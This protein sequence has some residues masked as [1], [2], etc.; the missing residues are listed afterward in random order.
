MSKRVTVLMGGWSSEREVSLTSGTECAEALREGG[1]EVREI[2]VTRDLGRLLAA[3]EPCPNVAFNALHGRYGEDGTIQAV[4]NILDIPYT[5]SGLLASATAMDKARSAAMRRSAGV[6]RAPSA[7]SI[8]VVQ[9]RGVATGCPR[10]G[11]WPPGF[12][13]AR[14][15]GRAVAAC[16][17]V[18]PE[19]NAGS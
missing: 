15:P 6:P 16:A 9:S 8:A 19:C 7:L 10:P 13:R 1:Y 18:M 2:D 12:S 5:H 17:R 14:M 11:R 4:L 3:L